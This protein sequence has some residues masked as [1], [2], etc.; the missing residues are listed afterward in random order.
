MYSEKALHLTKSPNSIKKYL[1]AS[2]KFGDFKIVLCPS[3]NIRT[4]P[5]ASNL[6]YGLIIRT[7]NKSA[8]QV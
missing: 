6:S 7:K 3:Q 5:L 1:E 8:Q 2:K 4:L